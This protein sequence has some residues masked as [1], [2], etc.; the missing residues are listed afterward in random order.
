[1]CRRPPGRDSWTGIVSALYTVHNRILKL[2]AQLTP[3]GLDESQTVNRTQTRPRGGLSAGAERLSRLG[4][5]LP[6]H[7]VGRSAGC[8]LPAPV[9]G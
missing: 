3:V 9:I 5:P 8:P 4:R 2:T 1:M 7:E 6:G